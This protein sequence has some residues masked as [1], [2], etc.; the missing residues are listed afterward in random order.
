[1]EDEMEA[2]AYLYEELELCGISV[3]DQGE[4]WDRDNSDEE[5]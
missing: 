5:D 2:Q 1:M 3:E 4:I